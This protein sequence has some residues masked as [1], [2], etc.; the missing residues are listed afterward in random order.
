MGASATPLALRAVSASLTVVVRAYP[1]DTN[2][3]WVTI[4]YNVDIVYHATSLNNA[5][6]CHEW[7]MCAIYDRNLGGTAKEY[8]A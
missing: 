2:H 8:S 3:Q 1:H 6:R 5:D 4:I 7:Q